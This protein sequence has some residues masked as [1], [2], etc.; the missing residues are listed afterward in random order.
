MQSIVLF[1]H[2]DIDVQDVDNDDILLLP[3]NV[4]QTW[5]GWLLIMTMQM[6]IHLVENKVGNLLCKVNV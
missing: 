3:A 5:G 4:K 1:S 2:E 6:K